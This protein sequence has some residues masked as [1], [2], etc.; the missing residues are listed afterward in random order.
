MESDSEAQSLSATEHAVGAEPRSAADN[1]FELGGDSMTMTMVEFRIQEEFPV[2]LPVGT[3]L[4]APSLRALCA[5]ID[6]S[7]VESTT[8]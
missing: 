2:E 1:F 6:E 7:C 4:N 8:P 5:L 3:L